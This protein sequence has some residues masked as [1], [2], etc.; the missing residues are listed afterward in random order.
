[1]IRNSAGRTRLLLLLL[2]VALIVVLALRIGPRAIA[3]RFSSVGPEVLWLAVPYVAGSV[4]G[5]FPWI[6]LL[7]DGPRP[8]LSA[9][10]KSRLAASGAN[11]L[12][13]FFALA[14]EPA[15]L[16][17]LR[18]E[19]RAIGT[20]ALIV[21]RIV[22]N[23]ASA[24]FLLAGVVLA[25]LATDLPRS[26][27]LGAAVLG[28]IVLGVT[29]GVFFAASRYGIGQRVQGFA[30]RRFALGAARKNFGGEVDQALQRLRRGPRRPLLLGL[31]TH[32]VGR[33]V[34]GLEIYTALW[35]LD[36]PASLATALVL[37]TV[38]VATAAVGSAIPSQLGILEGG[39][40]WVTASLGMDPSVGISLVLLGRLRQLAFA[41]L[42]VFLVSTARSDAGTAQ[43]A[44][45]VRDC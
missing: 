21:D 13:P 19:Q 15:R 26:M 12:L 30:G 38:Q 25:L 43:P 42:T 37:A 10:I 1:M 11:A 45:A 35:V 41:P 14:G 2:G 27:A 22:Y 7:G 3:E 31:L 32:F 33:V 9:T 20:A 16:L 24:L 28:V 44:A 29:V 36:V 8:S 40:A 5:A 18:P 39:Q 34:L 4:I 17:W 6:W 23:C